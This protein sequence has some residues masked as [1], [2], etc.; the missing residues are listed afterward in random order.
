MAVENT[1]YEKILK[2]RWG[3]DSFRPLQKEIIE[4]VCSGTDTLAI[5]P[6]GGG[7]S[8]TYQVPA[9]VLDG[10]VIVVSPLIALMTDQVESLKKRGIRAVVIHA[11]L[12]HNKI[13]DIL[14]Q[15][16]YGAYKLIYVSPERLQSSF[17]LTRLQ[18]INISLIAVDEA[19]CIS[20]W[21]YDFRPSY[22][23]I[24]DLREQYPNVPI[25]ALTASATPVVQKDICSKL[26]MANYNHFQTGIERDNL[27]YVVRNTKDKDAELYKILTAVNGSSIVYMRTRLQAEQLAQIL[28]KTGLS[29]DFYH[30]GLDSFQRDKRQN[31]WMEGKTQIL[32]STNAFGMGI[33]KPDVRVVV[34]YDIPDALEQYYQEAGR[35]GRDGKKSYAVLLVTD[36]SIERLLHRHE[37]VF[38]PKEYVRNVYQQLANYFVIGV[39]S[40]EGAVFPFN[41]E[42]FCHTCHLSYSQVLASLNIL[43]WAGYIT[44]VDEME[45]ASKLKVLLPPSKLFDWRMTQPDS[46]PILE[47]FLRVYTGIFSDYQHVSEDY[48][49]KALGIDRNKIYNH[50]LNL[51]NQGVVDYI[52][53]K[54]SPLIIYNT[55]RL[56]AEE[57]FIPK[58]AYESR[59]DYLYE[60]L[61]SMYNYVSSKKECRSVLLAKYFGQENPKPCGHC[62]YCLSLSVAGRSAASHD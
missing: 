22:L 34:H 55:P 49:A 6:T 52:P 19:H 47:A 11:A 44:L 8:L 57:L 28:Q 1:N 50:L 18:F 46:D 21:G 2:Q 51:S 13:F 54:R 17:F 36:S 26:K 53:F 42:Q 7:K 58:S 62:D 45:N 48:I 61:L 39:Y 20:E 23:K 32:C 56:E 40:G 33:D 4:S 38:P 3:Y 31:A 14:E 24:S 16:Q 9:M 15:A 60:R 25:L 43:Q 35:A 10:V 30:A 59:I 29:A 37:Q 12:S 5:L 41:L 27:Y